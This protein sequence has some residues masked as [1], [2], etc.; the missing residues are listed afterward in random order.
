M[1]TEV[2][3]I[4]DNL[5]DPNFR[6][7]GARDSRPSSTA[8]APCCKWAGSTVMNKA[9]KRGTHCHRHEIGSD[10]GKDDGKSKCG[11]EIFAHSEEQDNWE[12]DDASAEGGSQDG[13]LHLLP[14]LTAASLGDSPISICRKCSQG[15]R[16]SYR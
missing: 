7:V 16:R 10:Q 15:P 8:A 4:N 2:E 11:K 3:I 1:K 13:Q 5:K 6:F 14:P 9:Q 12:E